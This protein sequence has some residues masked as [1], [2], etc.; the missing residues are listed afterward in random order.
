MTC[1]NCK[2]QLSCGCQK[3]TAADGKIVCSNC[4]ASYNRTAA[5][6]PTAKPSNTHLAATINSINYKK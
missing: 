3:R 4:V 1:V 6:L 2:S 5:N